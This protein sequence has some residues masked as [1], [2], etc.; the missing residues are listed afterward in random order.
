MD[1]SDVVRSNAFERFGN[2]GAILSVL[3]AIPVFLVVAHFAGFGRGRAAAL[4]MAVDVA[5]VKLRW[6]SRGK[7]WFWCAISLMLLI[8]AV[9]VGFVPLGD[10]SLP[11]YGLV[12]AA[13]VIY[14]VDECIIFLFKRGFGTRRGGVAQV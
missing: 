4:C 1:E 13:V 10:E 5:V 12:P 8:Q 3:S 7:L 2:R 14:L 9:M 11:A 6:D